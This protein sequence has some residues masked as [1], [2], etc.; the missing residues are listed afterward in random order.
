M[1]Y[2]PSVSSRQRPGVLAILLLA[3][4]LTVMAGTVIAPVLEV[5]RGQFGVSSTAA[6]LIVTAHALSLAL[7]SPSAG[8]LI[9]RYGVRIPLATGLVLYGLTGGAGLFLDGYL[10]LLVS[11]LLFGVAAALVFAGST[12][13]LLTLYQGPDRDRVMG[14]RTVAQT[15]GGV[16]W[17]LLA[18]AVGGL[19]WHAPFALYLAGLPLGLAMLFVLPPRT[20]GAAGPPGEAGGVL[21]LLRRRP[22]LLGFYALMS[23]SALLLYALIVF[24]PLRLAEIGIHTPF[25]VALIGITSSAAG[26]ITGFAYGRLAHRFGLLG[27]LR[28]SA[29]SWL[30]TF[31]LLG[32]AGHPLVIVAALALFG[33]GLGCSGSAL[34]TLISE[35]APPELRGRAIALSGTALFAAQF[36]APLVIGPIAE[37]TSLTTAFGAAAV[38][39]AVSLLAV[40]LMRLPAGVPGAIGTPG[41]PDAP[42]REPADSSR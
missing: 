10:P 20:T 5:M 36:A 16:L 30:G 6:G 32:V 13:A 9:D 33:L 7:A 39:A 41:A 15:G 42:E 18:G 12:L 28:M 40:C 4:S 35:F 19:S 29:A 26:S 17:P 38:L 2:P 24:M 1:V 25:L 14:W 31:L 22:A 21:T 34:S 37:A 11:R 27:L 3:S 23:V 8:W